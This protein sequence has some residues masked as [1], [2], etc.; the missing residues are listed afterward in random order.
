MCRKRE[1]AVFTEAYRRKVHYYETDKMGVVHHSNYIR[2]FEEARL[3]FLEQVGW[4]YER[5][6]AKG[7]QSPVVTV[8]CRYC[9][10]VYY[11]ETLEIR[12]RYA[13]QGRVKCEFTYEVTEAETGE[14]RAE[15][16]SEHCFLDGSGRVV[17][18]EK[19]DPALFQALFAG[20]GTTLYNQAK[21][22]GNN[23]GHP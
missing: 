10:P 18:L 16:R 12:V 3:D 8:S 5:L 22:E 17:S 23:V 19:A 6:E 20:A 11:G 14:L 9:K 21:T 2:Y 7:L 15:G 1:G 13:P 4:P